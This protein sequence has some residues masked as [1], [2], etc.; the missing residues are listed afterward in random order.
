MLAVSACLQARS[1]LAR[2]DSYKLTE[3]HEV[4]LVYD[5]ESLTRSR[6]R[7]VI[8]ARLTAGTRVSHFNTS[9]SDSALDLYYVSE[10]PRTEGLL[11]DAIQQLMLL[12]ASAT[13][14]TLDPAPQAA[15]Q[16]VYNGDVPLADEPR[17][18]I[19]VLA[20]RFTEAFVKH[21]GQGKQQEPL[22]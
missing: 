1:F 5:A 6:L 11:P 8:Q 18:H 4:I 16:R 10:S 21:P 19:T 14:D 22:V 3:A 17:A 15:Y 20:A 7:R 12:L 13:G 2:A 9:R